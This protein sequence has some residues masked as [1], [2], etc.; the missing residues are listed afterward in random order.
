MNRALAGLLA[1][2]LCTHAFAQAKMAK[3]CETE[4]RGL[5][6]KIAAE[7]KSPHYQSDQGRHVLTTADRWLN[8]A[9]KHAVAG[10]SRNCVSAAKKGWAQMR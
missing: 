9:R 6:A 8:Q 3:E 4:I 2:L 7:R 1:L 10:E 5:E